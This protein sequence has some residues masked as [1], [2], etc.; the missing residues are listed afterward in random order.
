MLLTENKERLLLVY[1]R[2]L[3]RWL[4]PGGHVER[5]DANVIETACR[6]VL[7]ETGVKARYRHDPTPG[8]SR[9]P[10]NT[11]S[12]EG[13]VPPATRPDFR[14]HRGRG[15]HRPAARN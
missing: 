13:T 3:D 7:E 1:R 5:G 14:L 4:Q 10:P 8:R 11:G 2:R 6:E 15:R 12:G 9:H